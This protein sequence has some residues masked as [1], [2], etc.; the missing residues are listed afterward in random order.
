MLRFAEELYLLALDDKQGVIK[1]LPVSSLDYA[2]AGAILMDLALRDRIDTDL[3]TLRVVSAEPTGDPVLD[4]TLQELQR[5]ADPPQ[6]TSYWLKHFADQSRRIQER[7]LERLIAKNILRREDRR[8]LWVFQVRR[9]P[10][11]DNREIKEVRAR[12]HDL[13]LS[14]EI[15]DPRDVVLIN[16][17]N[18]CRLLDD[19]FPPQDLD[20]LRPRIAALARLDLIG[21]EMARSIREI[22]RTMAIAM[23]MTMMA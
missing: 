10:L 4:D 13:I 3:E 9:Y 23:S 14:D 8:I 17:A 7:V 15:P 5:K 22:E 16:L 19:L 21:Q 1:P 20:R 6:P 2:L 18:A 11:L 12:L